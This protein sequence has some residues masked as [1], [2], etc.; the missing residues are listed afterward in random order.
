MHPADEIRSTKSNLLS[1]KQI[2]LGITGSIAAVETIKL[3]RELIRHGA[4][5]IPV[6]TPNATKIIHPDAIWFATGKKPIIELTGETEHISYCGRVKKPADILLICPCTANTISKIAHG[7]DD[8]SV[9]TFATTALGS[10]IP[11]IVVPAMHLSMY[12]HKIIQE[13]IKKCK[14]NGIKFIEPKIEKNKA[15]LPEIEEITANIIREINKEKLTD[16]KIL[17][18]GGPTSEPIDDVRII[19]NRSSGKTAISLAKNAFY[20]GAQTELW[21]GKTASEKPPSFIKTTFFE[22]TNDLLKM[23]NKSNLKKYDIIILCAAISDYLPEKQRGKIS[24]GK[25]KLILELKP[26]QKI[27]KNIREETKTSK[28]KIIAFKL[29]TKKENL[30]EKATKLLKQNNID[31]VIGNTTKNLG[32]NENE[33]W[34]FSK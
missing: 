4:E 9:T 8:T 5:V 16:K 18:I 2:I 3:S 23:I 30:K 19:T 26:S 31:Y 12:D 14:K 27:I 15:K 6:M 22:T 17:I 20:N 1:K 32:K 7:I 28:T 25:N 24:S 34:I 10:K 33:I 21:Y 11:I 29:E 13:N